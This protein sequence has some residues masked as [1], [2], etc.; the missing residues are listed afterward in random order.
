MN[1]PIAA[2]QPTARS[3]ATATG[4]PSTM[5]R[6]LTSS[7]SRRIGPIEPT[8]RSNG[9][10]QRSTPPPLAPTASTSRWATAQ[11]QR[12]SSS[13]LPTRASNSNTPPHSR[14]R[15]PQRSPHRIDF[16]ALISPR[17][18]HPTA[19]S[20]SVTPCSN[21]RSFSFAINTEPSPHPQTRRTSNRPSGASSAAAMPPR[22]ASRC[23]AA[24]IPV[25]A[26]QHYA[27]SDYYPHRRILRRVTI[28]GDRP[29]NNLD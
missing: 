5:P 12:A 20:S 27:A 11:F 23:R 7:V 18:H 22:S 2:D 15:A 24:R 10:S 3:S 1:A 9:W 16:T 8:C 14:H 29:Y 17:S 21:A 26:A 19:P 25:R 4:L 6:S 28:S 13:A